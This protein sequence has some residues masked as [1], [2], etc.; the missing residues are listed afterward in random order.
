MT[1]QTRAEKSSSGR[2]AAQPERSVGLQIPTTWK[3]VAMIDFTGYVDRDCEERI[4]YKTPQGEL[5]AAVSESGRGCVKIEEVSRGDVARWL[6]QCVIPEEFEHDFVVRPASPLKCQDELEN[7][8]YRTGAL[9][10]ALAAV[11]AAYDQ[12]NEPMLSSRAVG[13]LQA[14]AEKEGAEL[15]EAFNRVC[16]VNRREREGANR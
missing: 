13:G 6:Q 4:I 16:I 2:S 11:V 10:E 14:I 3:E 12:A 8:I 1:N 15:R 7:A 5:K 9:N